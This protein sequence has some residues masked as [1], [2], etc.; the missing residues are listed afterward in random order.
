MPQIHRF[1]LTSM[2][3]DALSFLL[4]TW[5]WFSDLFRRCL[6][7]AS[8]LPAVQ[9]WTFGL[10]ELICSCFHSLTISAS[11]CIRCDSCHCLNA[12]IFD[13]PDGCPF[14]LPSFLW[15]SRPEY[16]WALPGCLRHSGCHTLP[17]IDGLYF[18]FLPSFP[19][20]VHFSC[21]LPF[22]RPPMF[23]F[24]HRW[25]AFL[26]TEIISYARIRLAKQRFT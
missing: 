17:A 18:F 26:F 22:F 3:F 6:S 14:L 21:L 11:F 24:H 13:I 4:R 15:S 5:I 10:A 8:W 7:G 25:P 19:L 23:L 1:L 16:L 12:Q 9:M 2:I 20:C